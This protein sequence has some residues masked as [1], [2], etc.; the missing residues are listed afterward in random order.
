[1]KYLLEND[2]NINLTTPYQ[3][4]TALMWAV[5][6]GFTEVVKLL[7]EKGADQKITNRDGENVMDV[8]KKLHRE[9]MVQL[10]AGK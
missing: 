7:V 2:A 1:M 8:A 3:N 9:D 10:L 5:A 4:E 6:M